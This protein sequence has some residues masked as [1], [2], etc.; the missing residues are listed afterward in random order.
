[1]ICPGCAS[2][3]P[4]YPLGQVSQGKHEGICWVELADCPNGKSTTYRSY[5]TIDF[6]FRYPRKRKSRIRLRPHPQQL[7]LTRALSC[8]EGPR[9]KPLGFNRFWLFDLIYRSL[10]PT[11]FWTW[12]ASAIQRMLKGVAR[13]LWLEG[14]H[15]KA[16]SHVDQAAVVHN[17]QLT[18]LWYHDTA[19]RKRVGQDQIMLANMQM[20]N[21]KV[22][23]VLRIFI[24]CQV[25]APLCAICFWYDFPWKTVFKRY[26]VS[27]CFRISWGY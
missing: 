2:R 20:D 19:S 16:M 26:R 21:N 7:G 1:M 3:A 12:V 24:E 11:D 18:E 5:N 27:G 8:N 17:H 9:S 6:F 14:M 15:M 22:T 13:M 23:R 10:I 4:C 25:S